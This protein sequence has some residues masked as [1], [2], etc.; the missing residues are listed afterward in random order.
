MKNS[1]AAMM[2]AL[3]FLPQISFAATADPAAA[4]F[5][6][7]Q[8]SCYQQEGADRAAELKANP[9]MF[10]NQDKLIKA[11]IATRNAAVAQAKAAG[12]PVPPGGALP[13]DS[14]YAAFVAGQY[15]KK[16]GCLAQARVQYQAAESSTNNTSTTTSNNT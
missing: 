9:T 16:Q 12:Q 13:E 11:W 8:V 7:A 5:T 4:A 1:M 10:A 15:A 6:T 2:V 14:D 3:I